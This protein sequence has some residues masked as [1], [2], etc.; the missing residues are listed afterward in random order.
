M[1]LMNGSKRARNASSMINQTSH[2]GS[3]SGSVSLVGRTWATRNAIIRNTNYCNCIPQGP[4]GLQYL[5]N[6]NLMGKNGQCSG[7][8]GR[9][10]STRF[11]GCGSNR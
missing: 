9:L 4:A 11:G 8:V 3:M 10:S 1:V 7:G 5:I 6:N 2:C